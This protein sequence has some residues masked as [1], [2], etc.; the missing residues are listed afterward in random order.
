MG[1]ANSG[2]FLQR[3]QGTNARGVKH[4]QGPPRPPHITWDKEPE[5]FL[6]PEVPELERASDLADVDVLNV[7]LHPNRHVGLFKE[8]PLDR[9]VEESGLAYT[10][11]P[12]DDDF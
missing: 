4:E 8:D 12:C 5:L 11:I 10:S 6:A 2:P 9:L 1:A 7:K 3:V